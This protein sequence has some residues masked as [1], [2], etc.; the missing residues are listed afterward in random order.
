[1]SHVTVGTA[2]AKSANPWIRCGDWL[3]KRWQSLFFG[4]PR[5]CDATTALMCI[6]GPSTTGTV[7]LTS[8]PCVYPR[9]ARATRRARRG[10]MARRRR[11]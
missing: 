10:G 11:A 7:H 2:T 5:G 1:M 3:D 4:T 6:S 8:R 9:R